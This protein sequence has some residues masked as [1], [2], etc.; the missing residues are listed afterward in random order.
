MMGFTGLRRRGA[1]RACCAIA[2]LS[3]G[4]GAVQ[5]SAQDVPANPPSA[6]QTAPDQD[7]TN[8][9]VV[10]AQKRAERLQ[11]VPIAIT[12]ITPAVLDSTNARNFAEL[13]GAVPGVYFAGNSGGGRTYITLRGATGL[14]LNT[15]DEPVAIYMDDIYLARGVTIGMSDLVDIGSVEIVR[16]PQGTLQGR[17]ATAGAILLRSADPTSDFRAKV[18]ASVAWPEEF[19]AQA[20]I[21]GPLGGGF[22][23]RLSGGYTTEKGWAY[24][25][26]TK[27]HIG[28]S[29]SAQGRL[30]VT[31]EAGAFSARIVADYAWTENFPA[32]FRYA[33]TN[34][35][36]L[37]TGA[38]VPAGTATPNTPLDPATRDAIFNHNRISLNP[39]TDTV[40]KGG[41]ISAKFEYAF[42]G[43]DLISV[44][45][46]RKAHVDGINDS[47]GLDVA[48]MGY[49]HN[50]DRSNQFS[51][52][53]RLQSSGKSRFSWILG[54]YLFDENQNYVDDIY[55]LRLSLPTNTVTRYAGKQYTRS[56]AAFADATF[57]ITDQFSVI[58]GIRYTEDTKR[59]VSTIRATNLDTNVSTVTP[60]SP[61]QAKW[62]DTSY[63]AKLVYKPSRDL[64]FFAGYGKGFRAGGYN[65][66]AV[67]VPYAPETNKSFEIGS[68]GELLDGALSFSLAAYRNKYSNLQLRAGVPTGGAIITNAAEALIKGVELEMTARPADGT[69]LTGNVAYTDAKFTSFP[70]ARNTLDQPVDASGNTL[71]RTPKWQFFV[72][73]EQDFAIGS[74][75]LLTAEAN[76]R[77]RDRIYFFFTDQNSQPWQDPP[78]DELGARLT[79]KPIDERWSFSVFGTNL[80]N[81]RIINTAAVTFSYPQVGLNK[82]RVIGVSTGFKF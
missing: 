26:Y 31:K 20:S 61:P 53:I 82:P 68:K 43:V 62:T 54:A 42:G 28:G 64:M 10:T 44:S 11:D 32:I 72:S 21:S 2:A 12:V 66:F 3:V 73:A 81:S 74:S 46:Y 9:I 15:G 23:A 41:G 27:A 22:E 36:P 47:D 55:N 52:E 58:G 45:G 50:D 14:A 51:Q 6:D 79:L 7:T 25:P 33:K 56:Y 24:N 8:D 18:S 59:L 1:L 16:G 63:R 76:Y 29:E 70:T 4:C 37:P 67:Q 60:Y 57:N 48:R 71:P 49:N 5:A 39:G 65:P 17:N 78:G 35:S 69:R 19:R 38:L 80:T 77:W 40:V 30:V 75:F 13:Q 34:F